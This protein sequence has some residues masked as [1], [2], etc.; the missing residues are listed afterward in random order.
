MI[1]AEAKTFA[2]EI[3]KDVVESGVTPDKSER[4][5]IARLIA[6]SLQKHTCDAI[7]QYVIN[8]LNDR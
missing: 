1:K 7:W 6:K 2:D 5:K 3:Y 4:L 8:D